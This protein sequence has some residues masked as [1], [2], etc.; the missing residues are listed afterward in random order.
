M[1]LRALRVFAAR[2]LVIITIGESEGKNQSA[3]DAG[4]DDK[5]RAASST[6][7]SPGRCRCNSHRPH[8]YERGG[9]E[10][11]INA[12]GDRHWFTPVTLPGEAFARPIF[13]DSEQLVDILKIG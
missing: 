8:H 5:R 2:V 12:L 11:G 10:A 1:A 6:K 13:C 7:L 4:R 3:Y 9:G